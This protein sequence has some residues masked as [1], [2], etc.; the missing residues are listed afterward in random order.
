MKKIILFLVL[1]S[2]LITGTAAADGRNSAAMSFTAGLEL[3]AEGFTSPVYM[4]EAPD[5][6]GRFFVVDQIGVIRILTAEG[7]LLDTPFLNVQDRLVTLM[8]DFDERGLLGLA[9]HPDY[10]NNGRF[11]VYYSAPLRPG[12]PAD[13]EHTATIAQFLVSA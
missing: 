6:S 8:P 11:F 1:L 12:A 7:Q 3:I 5:D 13:Y 10:A 9:F 4:T 2:A